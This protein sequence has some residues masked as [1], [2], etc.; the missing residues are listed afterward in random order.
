MP[1]DKA[2]MQN[3]NLWPSWPYLPVKNRRNP[4]SNHG[5][6][7]LAETSFPIKPTIYFMNIFIPQALSKVEKKDYNSF[8]ELIADGWAVD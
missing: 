4:M 2:M 8:D 6:G 5:T 1:N 7:A 3:P